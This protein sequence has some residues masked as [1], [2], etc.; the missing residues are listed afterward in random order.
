MLDW[1]QNQLLGLKSLIPREP[2]SNLQKELENL[3]IKY[4]ANPEKLASSLDRQSQLPN[5]TTICKATDE[6]QYISWER[7]K[8]FTSN[9][10]FYLKILPVP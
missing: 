6:A 3:I 10:N 7:E 8:K 9:I 2:D 4:L 5:S 1:S